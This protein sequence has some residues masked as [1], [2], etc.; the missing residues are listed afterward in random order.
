MCHGGGSPAATRLAAYQRRLLVFLSVATV[1]NR[2]VGL[3]DPARAGHLRARGGRRH[4]G[5]RDL[6]GSTSRIP[7]PTS[8]GAARR[9]GATT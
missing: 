2:L 4:D 5:I 9:F 8:T 3:Y 6:V 7:I 1:R